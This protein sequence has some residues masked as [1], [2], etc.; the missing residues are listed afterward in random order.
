MRSALLEGAA[1]DQDLDPGFPIDTVVAAVVVVVVA[2]AVQFAGDDA[3]ALDQV[4]QSALE[5]IRTVPNVW[6]DR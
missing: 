5:A 2:R 6:C 3:G 4:H 1:V